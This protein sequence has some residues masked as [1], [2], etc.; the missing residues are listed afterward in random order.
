VAI[1]KPPAVKRRKHK[2]SADQMI[3]GPR[4]QVSDD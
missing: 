2:K 4:I 1:A 3:A